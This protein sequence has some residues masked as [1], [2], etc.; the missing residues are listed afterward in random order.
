MLELFLNFYNT[1]LADLA[2]E[3]HDSLYINDYHVTEL[4]NTYYLVGNGIKTIDQVVLRGSIWNDYSEED[5]TI[6]DSVVPIWS[7][8]LG[9]RQLCRTIFKNV[10]HMGL[11]SDQ[12]CLDVI[13]Y[14]ISG[15]LLIPEV[16]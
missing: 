8:T 13:S 12:D 5:N 4:V 1:D 6:G 15:D 9:N 2:E 16:L 10:D 3:F 11:I 7:A 14:L